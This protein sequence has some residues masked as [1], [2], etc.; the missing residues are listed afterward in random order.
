MTAALER[1]CFLE[2]NASPERLDLRDQHIRLA[3]DIGLKLVI[4]TDSHR[5]SSLNNMKYGVY[6]ARRGWADKSTILNTLPLDEL[7][8]HLNRV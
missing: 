7:L 1:G 6:Q 2:V 8:D 5:A 3:K 4:S